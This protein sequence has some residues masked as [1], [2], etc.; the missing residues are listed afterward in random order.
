MLGI[1]LN[2]GTNLISRGALSTNFENSCES[3]RVPHSS[4]Q[5][6][7][8]VNIRRPAREIRIAISSSKAVSMRTVIL[9]TG[10]TTRRISL[11][12]HF[13]IAW[14][15][16]MS[17]SIVRIAIIFFTVRAAVIVMIVTI[18]KIVLAVNFVLD[19]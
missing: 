4:L 14:S 3:Y 16:R 6:Q 9:D 18:S 2:M 7:K 19:R 13:V 15:P 17:H 5:N 10:Y 11:I 8:I 12:V 1:Q